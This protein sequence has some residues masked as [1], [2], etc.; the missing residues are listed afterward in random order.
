[1]KRLGAG[2]IALFAAVALV[3]CA[4]LDD[5]LFNPT[6]LS[7]YQLDNYSGE[8]DFKLDASF[9]IA[10]QFIHEV[11]LLSND[12][13]SQQ[14]IYAIYIGDLSKIAT[15]TVILYC[16][17]NRDHM[18]FYWPRAKLLANVGGV[19]SGE[20]QVGVMM[21]DYRGYGKSGGEPS[22][23]GLYADVDAAVAWLQGQGLTSDRFMMYGYSLG[24]APATELTAYPRTMAPSRLILESP[25][26]SAEVMVQDATLL[27]L[28]SSY[29]TSVK[30]DNASK[31]RHV[32]QPFLWL[33]GT[34][35]DFLAIDSHGEVVYKNH[36]G[37]EGVD[38]FARRVVG[39]DHNNVPEV[40][41]NYDN[42]QTYLTTLAAFINGTLTN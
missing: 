1:M 4:R 25:F 5:N 15:A 17:G 41:G 14:V 31:I 42:F 11:A 37:T 26:A 2:L 34:K 29:V 10:P 22:E 16:H 13:D 36:P 20:N 7:A 27:A 8:V 18:D 33:H 6:R 32:S 24:T 28:P 3:G 9:D 30:I 12:G 35:D 40:M 21:V 23:K 38:K 39:A 19:V